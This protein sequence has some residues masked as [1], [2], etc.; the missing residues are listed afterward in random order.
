MN[1][2]KGIAGSGCPADHADAEMSARLPQSAGA[3]SQSVGL[4][5]DLIAD[6]SSNAGLV[7]GPE[8]DNL[9]LADGF[10]FGFVADKLGVVFAP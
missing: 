3:G 1:G 5:G 7:F 9:V 4:N 10:Y 6:R 2:S 8:F